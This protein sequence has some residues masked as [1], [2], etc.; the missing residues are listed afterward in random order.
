MN[1]TQY[2]T[3][4]TLNWL[5]LNN[6]T[7]CI[8][9]Q[10]FP[11]YYC[12]VLWI[13]IVE[14]AINKGDLTISIELLLWSSLGYWRLFRR[15]KLNQLQMG[16]NTVIHNYHLRSQLYFFVCFNQYALIIYITSIQISDTIVYADLTATAE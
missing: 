9:D 14:S 8:I 5:E 13:C 15:N 10:Y 7:I 6:D 12:F 16:E 11:V 1:I 3:E 2:W 4:S